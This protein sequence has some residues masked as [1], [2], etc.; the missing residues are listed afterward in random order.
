MSCEADF[1][2]FFFFS[3]CSKF[4]AESKNAMKIVE[5]VFSFE[6]NCILTGSGKLFALVR[7]YS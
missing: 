4:D 2:F 3:K 6:D 1:F 5:N 7:E